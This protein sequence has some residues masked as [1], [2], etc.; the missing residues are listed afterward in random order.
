MGFEKFIIM[1]DGFKL[2]IKPIMDEK[3][4]S[5]CGAH[6]YFSYQRYRNLCETYARIREFEEKYQINE[7]T[8]E[9]LDE[10]GQSIMKELKIADRRKMYQI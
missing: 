2:Q 9:E 10:L 7:A 6:K 5:I 3:V 8:Q 1:S 4:Y